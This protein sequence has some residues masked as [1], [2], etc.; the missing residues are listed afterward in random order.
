MSVRKSAKRHTL[1]TDASFRFERGVDPNATRYALERAALLLCE[2]TGGHI[3]SQVHDTRPT[4]VA[5][6]EVSLH[7]SRL[8]RLIGIEIPKEKVEG[9]LASLDIEVTSHTD[10]V[11]TLAVPAYRADVTREADVIEEILR[12]Y[13]FNNIP[14][15]DKLNASLSYSPKPDVEKVQN[16]L[17]DALV[18]RGFLETMSNSLTKASYADTFLEGAPER[19]GTTPV[20]MLNPLS[21]DLGVM[22]ESLVF[23]GLEAIE[24]NQNHRSPDLRLFEFGKTYF[25]VEGGYKEHRRLCIYLTGRRRPESWNPANT[26]DAVSF[27]DLKAEATFV[28]DKLGINR[29]SGTEALQHPLWVEGLEVSVQRKSILR[30]GRLSDALNKQFDLR[31]PVYCAELNW[32]VVL[33]VLS[34][35]KIQAQGLAKFPAVRRDLSL[36]VETGATFADLERS[37]KKAEKKLLKAVDLF[38]VYEGKNLPEGKKSYALSFVLQ[39]SEKTLSDK[40]ID[41]VMTAIQRALENDCGAQLR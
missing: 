9:V 14:F 40:H 17:S 18:A 5:P 4:P 21:S 1:S 6:T 28:L 25:R 24:R 32:D 10:G 16:R 20:A 31:Q 12:I 3:A 27:T 36:L 13:G 39:D 2:I 34:M 15:P 23:N 30:M 38:D 22:R 35:N 8:T 19:E 41:K 11:W 33:S 7:E 26:D 37:A 29:P